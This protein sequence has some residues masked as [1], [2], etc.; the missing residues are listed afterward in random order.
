MSLGLPEYSKQLVDRLEHHVL[1]LAFHPSLEVADVRTQLP[2]ELL[3]VLHS[4]LHLHLA[5]S[6]GNNTHRPAHLRVARVECYR[7]RHTTLWPL[8]GAACRTHRLS[9]GLIGRD[10][11]NVLEWVNI[12][13]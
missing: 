11:G 1:F 4:A 12:L 13:L 3:R 5:A 6:D 7:C 10:R 2:S 9:G 8:R